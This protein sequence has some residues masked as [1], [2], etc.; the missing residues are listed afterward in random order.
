MLTFLL[1]VLE[2]SFD[3]TEYEFS[4]GDEEVFLNVSLVV[5]NLGDS[6]IIVTAATDDNS[7]TAT[8][9][10]M[11]NYVELASM[12]AHTHCADCRHGGACALHVWCIHSNCTCKAYFQ[13]ENKPDLKAVPQL[14]IPKAGRSHIPHIT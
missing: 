1:S 13:L 12:S 8:A 5:G 10:G 7:T 2:F 11:L 14:L 6:I 9:T 3:P 4:E